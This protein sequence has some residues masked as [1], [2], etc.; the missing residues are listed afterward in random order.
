MEITLRNLQN[1]MI[2]SSMNGVLESVFDSVTHKL[3][4]CDKTLRLFIPTQ[5]RKMT[6]KLRQICGCEICI[7]SNHM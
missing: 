2:K 5:V 7:I 1:N 3:M 4:I 6:P